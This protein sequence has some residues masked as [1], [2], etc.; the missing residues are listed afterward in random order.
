MTGLTGLAARSVWNRRGTALLTIVS[1]TLAVTLLIGVEKIRTEARDGFYAAVSGT[2]LIV[3]ARSNPV[4]LLLAS[5][6]RIGDAPANVDYETYRRISGH[7]LVDWSVPISLG[8]SHRGYRVLGTNDA[9]IERYRYGRDRA[10]ALRE[11]AWFDDLFDV[12]LGAEVAAELGYGLG[13]ELVLSHGTQ[14]LSTA[15]HDTLP[16]RVSGIL[17]R[18]GTPIDRTLHVSLEAIEAIHIGWESG[19]KLPGRE[20]G[21]DAARA[22]DLT[23]ETVTAFLLGLKSRAAV[24]RIQQAVNVYPQEALTAILPAVAMQQFFSLVGIAEDALLVVSAF[25]VLVGLAGMMTMLLATLSERRREMAILRSVGAR[26]VHVFALLVAESLLLTVIGAVLGLLLVQALVLGTGPLLEAF[27][28]IRFQAGLPSP[29]EWQLVGA[30]I[31][32]GSLVSLVPGV[33]AYRRSL[34]D[35]LTIRI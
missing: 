27:A 22:A 28:G 31:V 35:G 30:V 14:A 24:F 8:D 6:F 4:Q 20:I 18:T 1:L 26:P 33:M 32:G 17:E 29:R 21:A 34:A 3:G 15:E 19:V 23:P 9:Y 11:G 10:L 5:V 16:F 7:P 13:R 2:D 12:V 25:V